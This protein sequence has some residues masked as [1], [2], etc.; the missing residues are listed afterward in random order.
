MKFGERLKASASNLYTGP[1]FQCAAEWPFIKR[2]LTRVCCNALRIIPAVHMVHRRSTC[3]ALFEVSRLSW[4]F[5]FGDKAPLL[6][7][8]LNFCQ[9]VTYSRLCEYVYFAG[10]R[11]TLFLPFSLCVPKCRISLK[12]SGNFRIWHMDSKILL[13]D[14]LRLW[15]NFPLRANCMRNRFPLFYLPKESM[16][17]NLRWNRRRFHTGLLIS[18]LVSV[19]CLLVRILL[20]TTCSNIDVQFL[21]NRR[22]DVSL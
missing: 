17:S 11:A 4:K 18:Q 13:G 6:G 9:V 16:K 8:S 15:V 3:V 7:A 22:N 20:P 2:E 21:R 10:E 14:P 1:A 12:L 19:S 5:C